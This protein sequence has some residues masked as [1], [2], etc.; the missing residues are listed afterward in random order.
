MKNKPYLP[1]I[2]VAMEQAMMVGILN[3]TQFDGTGF[4]GLYFKWHKF[5]MAQIMHWT[6]LKNRSYLPAI[7]GTLDQAMMFNSQHPKSLNFFCLF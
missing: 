4:D 3:G 2:I 1:E 5:R 7:V 6:Y